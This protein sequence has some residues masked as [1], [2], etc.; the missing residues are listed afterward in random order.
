MDSPEKV[1]LTSNSWKVCV[2]EVD[3][4]YPKELHELHNGYPWAPG[5]LKIKREVLSNYQF[6]RFLIFIMF[7]LVLLKTGA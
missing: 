3:L 7:L 5:K 6:Q 1:W 4:G 2:L